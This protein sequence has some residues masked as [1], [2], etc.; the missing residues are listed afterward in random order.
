[1]CLVL[2]GDNAERGWWGWSNH[3]PGRTGNKQAVFTIEC[4]GSRGGGHGEDMTLADQGPPLEGPPSSHPWDRTLPTVPTLQAAASE[5]MWTVHGPPP[6]PLC[7]P[8][9]SSLAWHSPVCDTCYRPIRMVLPPFSLSLYPLGAAGF[10][11]PPW[12]SQVSKQVE[13]GPLLQK[14][15]GLLFS[16]D[17]GNIPTSTRIACLW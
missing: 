7:E 15:V 4:W 11:C 5:T 12:N 1:M 8:Q 3:Y 9:D 6:R 13:F 17:D 16:V 2:Q 14:H 10:R